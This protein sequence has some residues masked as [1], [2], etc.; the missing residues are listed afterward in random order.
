M[1][2]KRL[3]SPFGFRFVA[4]LALGSTLNPMNSTMLTTALVPI[5]QSLHVGAAQT[6]WLIAGLY[7]TSAVAQPTMGRLG[8]LFGPRRVYL[9]SLLLVALAGVLGQIASSL[10]ELVLVR[11]L[12][13]VGTS[14]AYPAA[15]RLFRN[16][17]D[18]LGT[19]PPRVAMG[20]MSLAAIS[21]VA[22]GPLLGGLLTLAF[23]WHAIFAVNLPLAL[24]AGFF[25]LLWIPRDPPQTQGIRVLLK[26][27]DLKGVG[28]FTGF[29]V[30]LMSLLM[31]Q[32]GFS[33]VSL[34]AAVVFALV[35]GAYSRKKDKPFLDVR[36]LARNK[37]L[38]VTYLR[39][40]AVTTITYS[41]FY[42]FAQWLESSPGLSA[43]QAGLV[44][45]PMS[46]VA[47]VSSVSGVRT[48]GLRGPLAVSIG[49][50][51]LGC[52]GL[53]IMDHASSLWLIT[54]AFIFFGIPQGAFST[55]TQT[56][57]Y[58]QAPA[59]DI[60]SAAGLQR[61][62]GYIGAIVAASLLS[63]TYASKA[64]DLGLHELAWILGAA[65]VVLFILTLFDRTIPQASALTSPPRHP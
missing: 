56:A 9:V 44:T 61:T 25:V 46:V 22:V 14:G 12:I 8:D 32:K 21:T 43:A 19:P 51:V 49:A 47:A 64:S 15:M 60:G 17:A 7:M 10:F 6:G 40:L 16:R 63:F 35:L 33:W 39:V 28:L 30:S 45:L 31:N 37:P 26:E 20:V 42:G 48:K 50:A 2:S 34:A 38:V 58:L 29:L 36:M 62:F 52:A 24:L 18:A 41:V 65:S 13:G 53:L 59:K 4:P 54:G 11:I 23:G 55:A 5:A 3:E 27:I 1:T 57:I